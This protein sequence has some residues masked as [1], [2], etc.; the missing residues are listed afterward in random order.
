ML[1]ITATWTCLVLEVHDSQ[2]TTRARE[3]KASRAHP[4]V[5]VPVSLL[6]LPTGLGILTSI[7][8]R[9]ISPFLSTN[10]NL[11]VVIKN[12]IFYAIG[13]F[14][15]SLCVPLPRKLHS[16]LYWT[17]TREVLDTLGKAGPSWPVLP[18]PLT[19][20]DLLLSSVDHHDPDLG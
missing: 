10:W 6:P 3:N 17:A 18:E 2:L 20:S 16:T 13:K 1:W 9:H 14:K 19:T 4:T 11:P 12:I 7:P 5:S 15:N 8:W